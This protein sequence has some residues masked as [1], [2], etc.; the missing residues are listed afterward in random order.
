N[1]WLR[2]GLYGHQPHLGEFYISTG[3]LY[4]CAAVFLPLGLPAD[5]KFWEAKSEPS[6]EKQIWSGHDMEADHAL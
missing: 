3:S 4:L 5:D 2:I 1:G 6:I